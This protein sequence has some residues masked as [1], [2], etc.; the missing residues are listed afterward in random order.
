MRVVVGTHVNTAD[1]PTRS[2][3]FPGGGAILAADE[4]LGT[5]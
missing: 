1:A 4:N 2:L 5:A 3:A